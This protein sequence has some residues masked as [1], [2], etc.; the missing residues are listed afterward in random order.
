MVL[1]APDISL[2]AIFCNYTK[3]CEANILI[4]FP[5]LYASSVM[6]I[7]IDDGIDSMNFSRSISWI[8]PVR[9]TIWKMRLLINLEDICKK[10]IFRMFNHV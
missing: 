10:L 7:I 6:I 3:G 9:E 2:N 4:K 8:K 1:T 5:T